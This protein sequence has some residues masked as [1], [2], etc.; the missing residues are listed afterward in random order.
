MKNIALGHSRGFTLIELLV[1]IAVL[2]V[3]GAVVLV[4][5]GNF[6]GPGPGTIMTAAS[7]TIYVEEEG[8][9][10][11]IGTIDL[12]DMLIR[13]PR[14]MDIGDSKEVLLSL[15]PLDDGIC[16]SDV[17]G[18]STDEGTYYVVSEKVELYSVMR[19]DLKAASF[20]I[21]SDLTQYKEVSPTS[22]TDWVWVV[23]P[24]PNTV[25]EQLL[26]IEL[27]TPV[28]VRG[29]EELYPRAVYTQS[30]HILVREPFNWRIFLDYWYIIALTIATTI[31]AV[32]GVR[33]IWR[34]RRRR[35]TQ[36]ARK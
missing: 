12:G 16:E 15:V 19:A 20:M 29:Y 34:I 18:E 4:N 3:L 32:F 8:A 7:Y 2:S 10:K 27:N 14:T 26:V 5:V 36:K 23:T 28:R 31:A 22:R 30:I 17:I 9:Q 1:V 33:E 24:N 11:N 13:Y 25:G 21:S 6:F 35:K